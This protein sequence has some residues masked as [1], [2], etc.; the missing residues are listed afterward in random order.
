MNVILISR[1]T[2][3]EM[4]GVR[5]AG[6]LSMAVNQPHQEIFGKELYTTITEKAAILVI[7]LIKKHPFQ[8]ANK[9]TAFMAMDVFLRLNKVKVIFEQN[10]A[11]E[12]VVKIATHETEDFDQLKMFAVHTI[13]K[14]ILKS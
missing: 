12:F 7:N 14:H 5:D 8:N 4:I 6:A 3:D 13:D 9:R 1:Q 2:P 11:I 10:E